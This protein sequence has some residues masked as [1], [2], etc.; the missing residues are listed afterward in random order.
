MRTA[1]LDGMVLGELFTDLKEFMKKTFEL[2]HPKIQYA[3]RVEAVKNEIRKYIKRERKKVLPEDVDFWDF[4]CRF[5]NTEAEAQTIHLSEIDK[6]I[7]GVEAAEQTSF[8]LEILVK[9][10]HRA[11]K[12]T[13]KEIQ[14]EATAE[15]LKTSVRPLKGFGN[16]DPDSSEDN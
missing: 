2:T 8:Y 10:G 5:G 1:R 15:K 13:Y 7:A 4:D 14:A 3:R 11:K 6:C 12:P 16:P 9:P